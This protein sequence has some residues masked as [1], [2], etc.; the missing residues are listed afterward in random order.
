MKKIKKG[1]KPFFAKFLEVQH[2]EDPKEFKGGAWP[3]YVTMK[4]PS[5]IDEEGP[6]A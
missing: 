4:Y 5:D 1:K 6:S 2:V 3:K